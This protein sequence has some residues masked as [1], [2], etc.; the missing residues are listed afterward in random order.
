MAL[1]SVAKIG[2]TVIMLGLAGGCGGGGGAPPPPPP[3]PQYTATSGV[4][5]KGPL[6]LGSSVTA[7]ELSTTL[8]PTGKQY[9][10]QTDSDLGTFH[11]SSPFTSQYIGVN[12]TGYYFDE[13]VNAIS[14]G[15]ITLNGYS[16]LSAVSVLNVN[17]LTTLAYQ[18][19]QNLVTKSGMSFTAATTQAQNEVLA[20][21]SI[22]N[23]SSFG[24]FSL[25]TY[26]V[27]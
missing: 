8:A 16:D 21:F 27:S 23:G 25:L 18:R 3:A 1:M 9:S 10:Y 11:P 4:A 19:I 2:V 20:A 12:A 17:L 24:G 5:Q 14:G 26:S 7:Q 22:Q 13:A 15:P 6:I